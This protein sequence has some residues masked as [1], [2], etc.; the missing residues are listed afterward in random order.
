VRISVV[1]TT[2]NRPD[3][4]SLVL[5][6]LAAQT[7]GEFEVLVADDGSTPATAEMLARLKPA[8][9]FPLRHIWQPDDGFRTLRPT[10]PAPRPAS[11]LSS[12]TAIACRSSITSRN[13]AGWRHR[14]GLSPAIACC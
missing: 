4:L 14:A 7:A 13:I 12:S 5:A 1:I 2:Y 9:N 10:A 8:L 6:G 11:T 3:A